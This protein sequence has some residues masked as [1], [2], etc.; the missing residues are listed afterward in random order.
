MSATLRYDIGLG[1]A[2]ALNDYDGSILSGNVY[3]D[4]PFRPSLLAAFGA[5]RTSRWA[6]M[7]SPNRT[8][9]VS[10][11]CKLSS[12]V[13]PTYQ[14]MHRA[15]W[16][17]RHRD[18]LEPGLLPQAIDGTAR[19]SLGRLAQKLSLSLG[20]GDPGMIAVSDLFPPCEETGFTDAIHADPS[21][22]G[23]WYA[24]A[25]W[26]QDRPNEGMVTRG[27]VIAGW[28][29]PKALKM[30]YGVPVIAQPEKWS[31][32]QGEMPWSTPTP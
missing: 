20:V 23:N 19:L 16:M 32:L 17:A 30:K 2:D 18:R 22:L 13:G 25:D 5:T 27:K 31:W 7:R 12:Q 1:A 15:Y 11:A 9:V 21:D 28:L 29:G 8:Q 26:L 3:V 24:Y 4:G 14:L 10:F 6:G